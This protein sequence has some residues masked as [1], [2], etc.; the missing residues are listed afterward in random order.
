MGQ[1]LQTSILGRAPL[2]RAGAQAPLYTPHL[3]NFLVWNSSTI[4]DNMQI[5]CKTAPYQVK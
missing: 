1:S 2:Y 3:H 5:Y 4:G